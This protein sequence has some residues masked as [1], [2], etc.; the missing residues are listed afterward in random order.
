MLIF[1]DLTLHRFGAENFV[2]LVQ[3]VKFQK[4]LIEE[5]EIYKMVYYILPTCNSCWDKVV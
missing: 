2:P 1:L 3:I 5:N 4:R